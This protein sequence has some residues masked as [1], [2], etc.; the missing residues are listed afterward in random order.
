MYK[1][2]VNEPLPR[3]CGDCRFMYDYLYCVIDG[4]IYLTLNKEFGRPSHCKLI[5]IENQ[6]TIDKDLE[7][8]LLN[9]QKLS[10]LAEKI[11][12]NIS[13]IRNNVKALTAN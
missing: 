13:I 2:E 7:E 8:Q 3:Y 11:Q 10:E 9:I 5:P 4:D 12:K 1:I 6:T